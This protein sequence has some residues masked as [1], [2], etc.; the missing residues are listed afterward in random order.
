MEE[1]LVIIGSGPAG[2]TAAI[3][4]ARAYLNPVLIEGRNPGGQLMSTT[5]VENWPGDISILGPT[6]ML[7]MRE[8]A[9]HFG[10]RFISQEVTEVDLHVKPFM[11]VTNKGM[12]IAA[13]A[14]I[15]ASGATPKRLGCSGEDVYWGKGVTTCAICDGVFYKNK[16]V[17]IVGGGDTAMED[18]SFMTNFTDSI[19]IVHILPEL[20][21][22]RAMQK[23]VLSDPRITII[24][25]STVTQI[26][27]ENNHVK[28]VV[29][30][31]VKT[32]AQQVLAADGVFVAIG[33]RPNTTLFKGQLELNDYGYILLK[34]GTHTSISGVFAAGDVTDDRYRQA[35]TSA[36]TGCAAALD[37][38]KYLRQA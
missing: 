24:Y 36:G 33:L 16:K 20:T 13:D 35:V 37:A 10:T 12:N 1:K 38:E 31:N 15:I 25:E 30:T 8:H 6:L 34:G 26:D 7:T 19:T 9:A 2:L 14:L 4:S 11:L 32:G 22:S 3:Y 27:G 29:I 28:R 18:A 21:A 23:R 5:A 17:I